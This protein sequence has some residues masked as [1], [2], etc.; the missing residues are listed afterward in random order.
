MFRVLKRLVVFAI[1]LAV[2]GGG[3]AVY[4]FYTRTLHQYA[5]TPAAPFL[6]EFLATTYQRTPPPINSL[7][8]I[9]AA[10][11]MWSATAPQPQSDQQADDAMISGA[12]T[13][14]VPRVSN[15][16]AFADPDL[17][18]M[19]AEV[20][21]LDAPVTDAD[22]DG[23]GQVAD[24]VMI[25][26]ADVPAARRP[27][28]RPRIQH[29]D[30]AIDPQ[31]RRPP[32]LDTAVA[33]D[34]ADHL[35]TQARRLT[36]AQNR[37]Q[38]SAHRTMHQ[39]A[40]ALRRAD[41]AGRITPFV[42]AMVRR[43]EVNE[44]TLEQNLAVLRFTVQQLDGPLDTAARD[45]V[46]REAM[47][48]DEW[49]DVGLRNDA[50]FDVINSLAGFATGSLGRVG[51]TTQRSVGAPYLGPAGYLI[52]HRA[53]GTW[54]QLD[55][56]AAT[57]VWAW[58]APFNEAPAYFPDDIA[59]WAWM[60]DRPWSYHV[61]V[62]GEGLLPPALFTE[63]DDRSVQP[64]MSDI[65]RRRLDT[66]LLRRGLETENVSL[67]WV[68]RRLAHA[69][70]PNLPL[71]APSQSGLD[72]F[73]ERRD[74]WETALEGVYPTLDGNGAPSIVPGLQMNGFQSD[75]TERN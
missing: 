48:L 14:S 72:A 67:G 20:L 40:N 16:V 47:M 17:Q 22:D 54:V 56:E 39:Y 63:V 45:A 1:V 12:A 25:A 46:L 2:L 3:G 10:A 49:F 71:S 13:P 52:G 27:P 43:I 33:R 55:D 44:E 42:D 41:S 34:I 29:R 75:A 23:V 7:A 21:G 28:E 68:E 73:V 60:V 15:D 66:Y 57:F 6:V 53:F 9:Q 70:D 11:R 35:Y 50:A 4:A 38:L 31:L 59:Y 61:D 69:P 19:E 5:L 37:D 18:R 74:E 36:A 51:L 30:S 64:A 8:R 32:Q 65:S 26:S 62:L 58:D 24:Q